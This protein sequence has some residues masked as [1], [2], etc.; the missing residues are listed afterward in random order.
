MHGARLLRDAPGAGI[1]AM[2]DGARVRLG[3]DTGRGKA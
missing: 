2:R 3:A 1:D